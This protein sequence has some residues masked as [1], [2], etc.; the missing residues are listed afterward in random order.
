MNIKEIREEN[1]AEFGGRREEREGEKKQR[2][3]ETETEKQKYRQRQRGR[4]QLYY[5][6]TNLIIKR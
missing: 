4:Q 2:D 1:R 5:N 6:L 3:R